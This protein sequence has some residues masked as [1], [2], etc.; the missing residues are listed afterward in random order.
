MVTVA[1]TPPASATTQ[2]T[3]VASVPSGGG[4]TKQ[5]DANCDGSADTGDALAALAFA[6]APSSMTDCLRTAGDVDCSGAID[7][8]DALHILSFSAGL[9]APAAARCFAIG[10]VLRSPSEGLIAD[11]LDAGV[12][13]YETSLLYRGYAVF[14]DARLPAEYRS[15]VP[16]LDAATQLFVDIDSHTDELSQATLDALAPLLARPSDPISIFSTAQAAGAQPQAATWKSSQAAGGSAR[17]WMQTNDA[18][19]PLLTGY[20]A[21]VT[22]VWNQYPGLMR[23]PIADTPGAAAINP[24]GAID[25]YFTN[26]STVDPR[27]APCDPNT[28]RCNLSGVD[29]YAR[30]V[31]P[32]VGHTSSGYL[33]MNTDN[34]GDYLSGVI[35][36]E[37]FHVSQFAYDLGEDSWLK[38]ATATWGEF[39]VLQKLGK[40]KQSVYQYVEDFQAGLDMNLVRDPR[41]DLNRYGSWQFFFFAS[42]KKGDKVVEDVWKAA[43]ADGDQGPDAVD[44]VFKFAD[45][46][47][48]FTVPNWNHDYLPNRYQVT[49]PTFPNDK[50][51]ALRSTNFGSPAKDEIKDTYKPL[52]ARYYSYTFGS[53]IHAVDFENKLRGVKNAHI[54]GVAKV[55]GEWKAPEDWTE[56]DHKTWCLNLPDQ[57]LEELVLIVSN[58]EMVDTL[59]PPEKPSVEAKAN[60]CTNW[61]GTISWTID[62]TISGV[63]FIVSSEASVYFQNVTEPGTTTCDDGIG[64][65]QPCE[66][67]RA[68]GSVVYNHSEVVPGGCTTTIG[69]AIGEIGP[70]DA[71][72]L[73]FTGPDAQT[74]EGVAL[75]KVTGP[76]SV[77]CPGDPPVHYTYD[78]MDVWFCT[79]AAFL[80]GHCTTVTGA[81]HL[82]NDGTLIQDGFT[83]GDTVYSWRLE[84][85]P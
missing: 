6:A 37:L 71:T 82:K 44:Q 56:E 21:K 47:D 63:K 50:P 80:E 77:I 18:A 45:N 51:S 16:N 78:D 32:I 59:T 28:N 57:Q 73:I 25:F 7:G 75:S 54:W 36:H 24:D 42:I 38:E 14:D 52:S 61:Q 60:A 15:P 48:D 62:K 72:L 9:S 4:T 8:M 64:N 81:L 67:Y 23:Y 13:D 39:R 84:P 3:S 65:S 46:F 53:A 19:D 33:M 79:P 2:P 27:Y 30:T 85:A 29:G 43:A 10:E 1:S 66:T 11:A 17:V 41:G 70:S 49:D 34:S 55:N 58:S 40:N 74:Y 5:G 12:I 35:A 76:A 22:E 20:A 31:A 26:A 83:S 69:P 68:T